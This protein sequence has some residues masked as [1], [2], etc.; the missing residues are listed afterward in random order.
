[1]R[2]LTALLLVLALVALAPAAQAVQRLQVTCTPPAAGEVPTQHKIERETGNIAGG[3]WDA[4]KATLVATLQVSAGPLT[5]K[6]VG[7]VTGAPHRYRCTAGTAAGDGVPSVPS[8][9]FTL[10]GV[11]GQDG[12]TVTVISE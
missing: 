3:A 1:M 9:F 7:A 2:I 6:D 8:Q 5:F 10:V 4:A 11:P 12:V